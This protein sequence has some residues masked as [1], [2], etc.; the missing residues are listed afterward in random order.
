MKP[1]SLELQ[2]CIDECGT[3]DSEVCQQCAEKCRQ[4][5]DS[6]REMAT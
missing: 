6:C 3:F 1:L 5:A 4:C 2:N